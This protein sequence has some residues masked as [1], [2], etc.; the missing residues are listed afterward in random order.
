MSGIAASGSWVTFMSESYRGEY[1]LARYVVCG[2][3][4]QLKADREGLCLINV[5]YS[6]GDCGNI[7]YY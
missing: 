3:Y 7:G 5:I 1:F 4:S 2:L 6:L